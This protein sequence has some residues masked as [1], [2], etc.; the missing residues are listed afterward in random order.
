MT[1]AAAGEIPV[2][3]DDPDV[4]AVPANSTP[5]APRPVT[6]SYVFV[7]FGSTTESSLFFQKKESG[8]RLTSQVRYPVGMAVSG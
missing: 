2:P 7:S 8:R 3:N 1:S 5:M 4:T 6:E